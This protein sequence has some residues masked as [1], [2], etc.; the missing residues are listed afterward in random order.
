MISGVF[1]E[2]MKADFDDAVRDGYVRLEVT[3]SYVGMDSIAAFRE[4]YKNLLEITG[5]D[6]ERE[7]AKITMTIEEFENA[8]SDPETIFVQYCRD[9]LNEA[10][11][12]HLMRLFKDAL[13]EY[14]REAAEK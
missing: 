13:K 12:E 8:G 2:L 3:D 6:F 9:I 4:K 11:N 14:D 7:D 10:P 5:K 1:T